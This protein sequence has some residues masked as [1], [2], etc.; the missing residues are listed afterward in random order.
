MDSREDEASLGN[1]RALN[2]IFNEVDKNIFRLINTCFFAKEG[3]DILVVAHEGTSKVKMPGL[4][5]LTTK[6][7]SLRM[8]EDESVVEFNVHLLDI[9]NELFALGEKISKEELVCKV[10]H[11]LPKRFD[12]KVTTIEEA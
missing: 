3:C 12:M 7:E 6:F 9:A 5:L 4:Q 11:S 10:L 2:A 1:S 8:L